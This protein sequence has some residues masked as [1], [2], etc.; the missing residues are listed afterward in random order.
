MSKEITAKK[1]IELMCNIADEIF[2]THASK[3]GKIEAL[4]KQPNIRSKKIIFFDP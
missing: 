1:R 2:I 4:L 3:G